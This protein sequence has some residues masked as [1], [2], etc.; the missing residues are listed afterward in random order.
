MHHSTTFELNVESYRRRKAGDKQN[1]L[2][3][4][5][6]DDNPANPF[7][8]QLPDHDNVVAVTMCVNYTITQRQLRRRNVKYELISNDNYPVDRP[9]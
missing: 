3:R 2:R 7:S 5:L 1:A 8:A 9:K 4:Q 6:H